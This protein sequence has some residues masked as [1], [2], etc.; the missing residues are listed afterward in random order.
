MQYHCVQ[1]NQVFTPD[2]SD[3]KP[4]CPTCLRQHGLRP[5]EAA[6]TRPAASGSS[7][8][9]LLVV[10][11]VV[12]GGGGYFAY[13]QLHG[14]EPGKVPLEPIEPDVLQADV[15]ALTGREVGP[16]VQLLATDTGISELAS[17]VAKGQGTPAA[18]AEAIC[19]ALAERKQKQGFVNWPRVEAREEPPLSASPAWAAS[20]HA[21]ARKQLYPLEATAIAV[22]ALRSLG[23]PALVAEVYRYP[24]E[25]TPL[26]PSGRLGYH[27]LVLPK[28]GTGSD[29]LFDPYGGRKTPPA[30]ADYRVLNDAQVI[31]A[32]LS[33][34]AMSRLDS[35]G[36]TRE[37]LADSELAIK[38]IP[39][40][41]SARSVRAALLL[42]TGGIEAGTHELDAALQLR[43][44]AP[45]RNNLATLGLL[46]GSPDAAA[47]EVATALSEAPDYALARV[48]LAT[49]HLMRGEQDL[50]R[51][52]LEKAE[53]LEPDL[54]LLPQIWAQFYATTNDIDRALEKAQ[55]GVRRRPK[56]A[57]AL[58]VLARIDRAAGRYDDMREQA[59]AIVAHAPAD[60]KDRMRELLRGMLGPSV[61][62]DSAAAGSPDDS[63]AL[64]LTGQSPS[65]AP[66]AQ[67]GAQ[68]MQLQQPGDTP[69]L[70]L[71]GG[72][73]RSKLR[74]NIQDP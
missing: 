14:H 63:P 12:A 74:L 61:L 47:K 25:H 10:G 48:T 37:A 21:G 50:A 54:A 31:G 70:Q 22:A 72:D 38:L 64:S 15:K 7:W 60:Q 18:K 27:A 66:R 52:E 17:R 45:R 13:Q 9:W 59:R 39:S 65:D 2:A 73:S 20:A 33:L 53:R 56:D 69:R 57:Q 49:V 30:A 42:A 41:A 55:E 3:D 40:S 32:A 23:V 62:E 67:D 5:V 1:C 71:G 36:D 4:R 51:A 43:S 46:S 6:P 8:T 19:A 44:D 68:P 35:G 16:L 28:E 34:R 58:L 24:N 11:L 29:Q 26:D